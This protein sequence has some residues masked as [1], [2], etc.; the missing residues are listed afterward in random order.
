MIPFVHTNINKNVNLGVP[1]EENGR[2]AQPEERF[3]DTEAVTGSI[4]VAPMKQLVSMTETILS[5][6]TDRIAA[7]ERYQERSNAIKRGHGL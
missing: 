1:K 6:C 3:S 5:R 7:G 2:I 4:P